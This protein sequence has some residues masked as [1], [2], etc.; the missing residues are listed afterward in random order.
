LLDTL[1]WLPLNTKADKLCTRPSLWPCGDYMH[2]LRSRME[3]LGM[4]EAALARR[5]KLPADR[6]GRT[7]NGVEADE[8]NVLARCLGRRPD[9]EQ[10]IPVPVFR[11]QAAREKARFVVSLVQG[12][13]GLEAQGLDPTDKEALLERTVQTLL[14]SDDKLW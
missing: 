14:A 6:V 9:A 13:M 3:A 2:S 8:Q 10:W 11:L 12:T 7:L 5:A 4:T 1:T